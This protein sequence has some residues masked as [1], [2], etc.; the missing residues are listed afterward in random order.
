MSK[1]I[2]ISTVDTAKMIRKALKESFPDIKFAVRCDQYANGS[3]IH[4]AWPDGPGAEMVE[5]IVGRFRE[6]FFDVQSDYR[7]N[8]YHRL[9]GA[10]ARF[11]PDHVF[12]HR[13]F[14]DAAVIGAIDAIYEAN[15]D[16]LAAQG[17]SK[18]VAA[19]FRIGDLCNVYIGPTPAQVP[20]H[21]MFDP[22]TE[23]RS[24]SMY[25]TITDW[26]RATNDRVMPAESVT[27]SRVTIAAAD[28][29]SGAVP[30]IHVH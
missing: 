17:V 15:R 11:G 26:L 23:P 18:P 12:C 3:S 30:E 9:D 24:R 16:I 14:S 1:I 25:E 27:A 10:L 5:S 21:E 19:T 20:M 8:L 2:S 4:V 22:I 28:N 6:S 13:R 29:V 7:D